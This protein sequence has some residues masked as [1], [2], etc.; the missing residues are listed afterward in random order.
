MRITLPDGAD[1]D[2]RPGAPASAL[3]SLAGAAE[4][5]CGTRRL[6]ADHPAGTPPLVHGARLTDGPRRAPCASPAPGVPVLRVAEG[7]DAGASVAIAPEGVTVGR[8]PG[9]DLTI[10]DPAVSAVHALVTGGAR[11]RVRDAGSTNGV[12]RSLGRGRAWPRRGRRVR[13]GERF[14]VGRSVLVVERP[15]PA[16]TN[17]SADARAEQ[18]PPSRR[19]GVAWGSVVAGA[20]AGITLAA[21]TGRWYLAAVGLAAP[22]TMAVVSRWR[23]RDPVEA[24]AWE[25]PRGAIAIIGDDRWARGYVRAVAIARGRAPAG[26]RWSEPW[27]RWLAPARD[28]EPLVHVEPGA[29]PPSWCRTHV[30]VGPRG[31]VEAGVGGTDLPPLALSE[32]TA[33]ALARAAAALASPPVLPDDVRWADLQP[34]HHRSRS[35]AGRPRS[36][37]VTLGAGEDG[38]VRL[39]LDRYGPHLLVA[40]TTGAGKSIALELIVAALAYAHPPKDLAVAIAD[41]KGGAG[42]RSCLALP[43]LCGFLTDLDGALAPRVV[44]AIAAELTERKRLLANRGLAS[45]EAWEAAESSGTDSGPPPRLLVVIDEYQ[46]VVSAHPRFVPDL[47]RLAAQGRALGLHL[48]LATQRPAGAVTPE[49]RANVSSTIALRV[50]SALESRD[51]VGTARAAEI[52]ASLPGRAILAR[53]AD[54]LEVQVATPFAAPSPPVRRIRGQA[55]GRRLGTHVAPRSEEHGASHAALAGDG[56]RDTKPL[57]TLAGAAAERWRTAAHAAPLWL[58]PLPQRW[59]ASAGS[60]GEDMAVALAD[61]PRERRQVHVTWDPGAGHVLVAGTSRSGRT[62]LLRALAR[63]AV[64]AGLTPVALPA[65]SREAA[66]TLHLGAGRADVLLLVDD[67]EAALSRLSAADDGAAADALLSRLALRLP[68]AIACGLHAPSRLAQGAAVTAVLPGADAHA[69][70]AWGVPRERALTHPGPGRAW[71]RCSSVPDGWAEAQLAW[72]AAADGAVLVRPLTDPPAGAWACAG[73]DAA[74]IPAP[75]GAITV[76]GPPGQARDL[77]VASLPGAGTTCVDAPHAVP[78]GTRR[79]VVMEPSTRTVRALA[80]RGWQGVVDP[81]PRP[82]RVAL[83]EDGVARAARLAS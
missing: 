61:L 71:V 45:F 44:D 31:R 82:G 26:D 28:D 30:E 37:V 6:D 68:T 23:S 36:L 65:D 16:G 12:G 40:G 21:L 8:D 13:E 78:P 1:V 49:V 70:S 24:Q 19:A 3:L 42:L 66:R 58:P 5:W 64:G 57:P 74:A 62:G 81:A 69:A 59:R 25:P 48:V 22:A 55:G 14:T 77:V 11:P 7:P 35:R 46:E 80:P 32:S 20:T 63:Q 83:I 52:P 72:E 73:D 34:A 47:A 50:S 53:G 76:V 38:P 27:M 17:R 18:A 9:C 41:F 2:V 10:D 56:D 51:L 29:S 43:H 60:R 75:T 79:V 4:L 67:A 54:L 39:D 33:D 15:L